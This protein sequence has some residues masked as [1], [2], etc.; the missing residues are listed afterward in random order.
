MSNN[1]DTGENTLGTIFIVLT[2][3]KIFGLVNFSWWWLLIPFWIPILLAIVIGM[4][5][6]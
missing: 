5:S 4:F 1:S 3:L 6:F 2:L